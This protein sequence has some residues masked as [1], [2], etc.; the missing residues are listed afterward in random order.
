MPT[1]APR[2]MPL[3]L[4]IPFND[5]NHWRAAW[6]RWVNIWICPSQRQALTAIFPKAFCPAA[7]RQLDPMQINL[8]NPLSSSGCHPLLSP[9]ITRGTHC[10]YLWN[11]NK[12]TNIHLFS[13]IS[14]LFFRDFGP[15]ARGSVFLYVVVSGHRE[16]RVAPRAPTFLFNKGQ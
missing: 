8:P 4:P 2:D 13:K 9:A 1:Y 7:S 5:F 16:R 12:C 11:H 6:N 14:A 15:V 10:S 3:Q